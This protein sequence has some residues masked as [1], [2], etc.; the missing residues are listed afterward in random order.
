M[1][2]HARR[3][4]RGRLPFP[5]RRQRSGKQAPTSVSCSPKGGLVIGPFH[6]TELYAN[7]GFGFHSND[8]RGTTIT[9]DPS[10]GERVD[11]VTPLVRAT[12]AEVGVRAVAIPHLQSS[13]SLWSLS[14]AS[15]LVFSGDAGTTEAGRPSHRYGVEWANYYHPRPWLIF[16]GDV[17]LSRSHFTD[18]DPVG[19]HIPGSLESV[20]S[21]GATVDSVRLFGAR[22]T[23][24]PSSA[25]WMRRSAR[26]NRAG[27][28]EGEVQINKACGWRS[29]SSICSTPVTSLLLRVATAG[30]ALGGINDI[31]FHPAAPRLR[32]SIIVG[33]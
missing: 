33:R 9:R 16:D 23:F 3:H 8:A 31:Q 25:D 27:Q 22:G 18:E 15:E 20:V 26:D 2:A 4:P 21:L 12:G 19:N 6:G 5:R 14:L 7:G 17:S 13:L 30:R 24:R 10:T 29:R 32:V 11:P 1:D 28:L